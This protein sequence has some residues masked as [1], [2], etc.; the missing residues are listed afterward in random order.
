MADRRDAPVRRAGPCREAPT[1]AHADGSPATAEP[2]TDAPTNGAPR[3]RQVEGL[4]LLGLV[5]DSGLVRPAFLVRRADDQVV[6]LTELLYLTLNEVDPARS[7]EDVAARVSEAYGRIL[8]PE[9]LAHLA[10]THLEPLGLVHR[11]GTPPPAS[12]PRANPLLSLSLQGTLLPARVVRPVAALLRP[13]F[14]P[15]VVVVALAA[16]VAL[17][18]AAALDGDFWGAVSQLFLTPTLVLVMFALMILAA[19]VHELGHA[20]ACRYG[21]AQPG[22]IGFGIYLVF[23]AF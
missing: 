7:P 2:R 22:A 18:V 17:D 14:W 11:N 13:F 10:T 5:P 3:W 16:L 9:G 15:P 21:G 12:P 20:T 23:P 19:V 1:S 4:E 6:Q 8:T